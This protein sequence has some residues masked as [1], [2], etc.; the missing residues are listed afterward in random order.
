[1]APEAPSL[2]VAGLF[3]RLPQPSS[4]SLFGAAI[5]WTSLNPAAPRRDELKPP[6]LMVIRKTNLAEDIMKTMLALPMAL[7]LAL[8]VPAFAAPGDGNSQGGGG[9]GGKGGGGGGGYSGAPGPLAGAGLPVL[10]IGGGIYWLVRRKKGQ[11]RNP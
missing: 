8:S 5:F 6:S 3:Y 9:G 4:A 7:L 2:S 10:L 11:A 1:M